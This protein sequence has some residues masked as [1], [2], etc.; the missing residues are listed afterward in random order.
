MSLSL[1]Q[2]LT[3]YSWFPLAVL[4]MFMLLI[5]RFYE[6]FSGTRTYFRWFAVPVIL[7]GVGCVRYASVMKLNGDWLADLMLGGAGIF[8]LPLS[9]RLYQVMVTQK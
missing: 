8:L 9:I 1:N 5:G 4:L 6:K 3:L 7:F 2:F